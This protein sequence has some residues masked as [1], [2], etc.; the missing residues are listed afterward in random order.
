[1]LKRNRILALDIGAGG[2]KLAEFAALKGGGLELIQYAIGDFDLDPQSDADRSTYITATLR[3]LLRSAHVQPGRVLLSVAG[4][5]VFSRFVKLPMADREQIFK[6]IS[7]EAQQNVPFPIDEVVWDYQLIGAGS[8]GEMDVMLVAIKAEIIQQITDSVEAA[9][10]DVDLV[11]VAPVSVY[12]CTRYNYPNLPECALI[13]DMGARSTDLI[14][15]ESRR[16]FIRSIPVAGNAITQQI[17]QEFEL[18]YAD[19]EQMKKAHAFVAFGGAYEGAQSEAVDKV[20]K[21]VRGVMT[22]MHAEIDRSIKFY[23]SQQGG[24]Q[25][26]LVL[27]TGGTS[28]IPY[29]DVFMKDKLKVDVDYL[30][31]FQNVAVNERVDAQA[32]GSDAHLMGELVGLALR[33]I[34]SCPVEINLMPLPVLAQKAFR[35]KQPMFLGAGL[36]LALILFVWCGFFFKMARLT[37]SRLEEIGGEVHEL[38]LVERRLKD[39]EQDLDNHQNHQKKLL[40]LAHGRSLWLDILDQVR[41]ALPE[42]MSLTSLQ[43]AHD[44][45]QEGEEAEPEPGWGEEGEERAA[46]E[47]IRALEISG[48]AYRDKTPGGTAAREFR[49]RLRKAPAFSSETEITWSPVPDPDDFIMEFRMRAVF[50]EPIHL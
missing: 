18:G 42:G 22:R 45:P 16:V 28:M 4:Q 1:M 36:V 39:H 44:A 14:F 40:Q 50:K 5:S 49:D 35:R 29:T 13:V 41:D 8:T 15:I 6:I 10:L 43:P 21:N 2:I 32:I 19:A 20:S 38:E 48:F 34:A 12:N 3:D 37:R 17:M 27:L 46:P 30:N 31:P 7:Y 23:R 11:D 24:R 47:A 9:G 33:R 25:P 26:Q